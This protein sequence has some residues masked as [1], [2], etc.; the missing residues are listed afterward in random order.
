[1]EEYSVIQIKKDDCVGDSVAIHNYNALTLDTKICN[2]S[3]TLFNITDN[4]LKYFQQ[5]NNNISLLLSAYD[6]FN[7]N[8]IFRYKLADSATKLLSG[9]WNKHE[10]TVQLNTNISPIY[11]GVLIGTFLESDFESLCSACYDYV[12]TK[13]PP[14][15]FIPMTTAHVVA[16]YYTTIQPNP[17]DSVQVLCNPPE[18]TNEQRTMRVD[19]TKPS[20]MV[21]AVNVFSFSN[22][23]KNNWALTNVLPKLPD[24]Y[25]IIFQTRT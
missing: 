1:M 6:E 10:F 25:K 24:Q 23:S 3:S 19:I 20:M 2:L 22:L 18:F 17:T 14:I 16:Y 15:S 7:T 5:Y 21:S 9:Y 8:K 11:S 4:Y 12:M 13:F